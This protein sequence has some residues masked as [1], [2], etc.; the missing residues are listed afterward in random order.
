MPNLIRVIVLVAI[1]W[2]VYRMIKQWRAQT[3]SIKKNPADKIE[4][5]VKCSQCGVHIPENE[6]VIHDSHTFCSTAHKDEYISK[7]K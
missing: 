5:I 1:V 2:L 7:H 4:T 3:H 6:A